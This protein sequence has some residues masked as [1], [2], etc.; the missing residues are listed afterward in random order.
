M[1]QAPRQSPVWVPAPP[2]RSLAQR[3]RHVGG[4]GP[5]DH[6]AVG[7]ARRGHELDAEAADVE[8]RPHLRL[9]LAGVAATGRNLAQL[10]RA[11]E[12]LAH[13]SLD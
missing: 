10:E 1:A 3:E 7:V 13:L 4:D 9:G 5:G 2:H 8:D 11:T 6:D 12:N